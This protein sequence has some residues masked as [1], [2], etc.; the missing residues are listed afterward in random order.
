M[1]SFLPSLSAISLRARLTFYF[2][3]LII[4]SLTV[5]GAGYFVK[6]SDVILANAS[7]T[8]LGLVRMSNRSINATLAQVEQSAINMHLD[9][10]FF[11]FFNNTSLED[12]SDADRR[13]TRILNK[14]FPYTEDVFSVNLVTKDYTFGETPS[15][16]IP[17][18]DYALSNI[19]KIGQQSIRNTNWIPTYNLLEQF[20][21]TSQLF[22]E[23]DQYVFTAT[24]LMNFA[25]VR[26]NLLREMG[27]N[28]ER[29]I[30]ILNFQETMIK[31]AFEESLTVEGSFYQ[32]FTQVGA[33]VSASGSLNDQ[34]VVSQDW[35]RYA[36]AKNSG[37][38]YIKINGRKMVVC[39]DTI[40]VTGWLSA[41][42]IPYDNLKKTV[43]NMSAYMFYSTIFIILISVVLA[44]FISGRITLPLKRLL[45]AIHRIGE[46]NF[47]SKIEPSGTMELN[48]IIHKFNQMNDKIHTL[49][50]ENYVTHLKEM[51]AELKALNFQFNPHF[52]YNT[53]NIINYL[54]IENKQKQISNMLVDLSEMLEYTAKNPGMVSF[55]EDLTYL[56]NY[57][58]IMNQRFEGKFT[59]SYEMDP[60]LF[61]YSVPK[62]FLQPFIENSLIHAL[63]DMEIGGVIKVS[64]RIEG[65]NRVFTIADNG[66]GMDLNTIRRVLE[67]EDNPKAESQSIGITNVNQRIKLLYGHDYGVHIESRKN[68]GTTVTIR[69][70]LS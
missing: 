21:S 68:Y 69:L 45:R 10:E 8:S 19:Y 17:K 35:I 15:F 2:I 52:L 36:A 14:Y 28:V 13:I 70:P 50:E 18:K 43:P 51:E 31:K 34:A 3:A 67:P 1:R 4:I 47:D 33:V 24:R 22:T 48:V 66:K 63:D 56:Q 32:M 64:G 57:V 5:M 6:S 16:W 54:A 25:A 7:E 59:V 39:F 37:T 42:F 55:K 58:F 9:E 61:H 20:Y 49:I 11:T 62:F 29:P 41:V 44:S 27:E 60:Q 46:G 40:P 65:V 26:N 38:E 30:L 53:L 12:R 23:K